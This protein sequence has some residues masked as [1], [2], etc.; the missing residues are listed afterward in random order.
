MQMKSRTY[1]WD[2]TRSLVV[3]IRVIVVVDFRTSSKI[4]ALCFNTKVKSAFQ[5]EF[6]LI[7]IHVTYSVEPPVTE[8]DSWH[9]N[10]S[11]GTLLCMQILCMR[12]T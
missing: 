3:A 7:E 6:P 4:I 8:A 11:G 1:K 12:I 5:Y 10:S 9:H 2:R